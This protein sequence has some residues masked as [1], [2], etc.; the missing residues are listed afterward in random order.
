MIKSNIFYIIFHFNEKKLFLVKIKQSF[1]M[2]SGGIEK[3]QWQKM[4]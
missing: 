2:F 4:G 3:D 1:F